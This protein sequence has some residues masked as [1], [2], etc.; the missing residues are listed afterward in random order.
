MKPTQVKAKFY[1]SSIEIFPEHEDQK[2]VNMMAA[3][4]TEGENADFTKYTPSGQHSMNISKET[5]AYDFFESGKYY[6]LYFEEAP[7]V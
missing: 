2:R 6:Y 3:Y 7:A 4:G 1:C 5:A